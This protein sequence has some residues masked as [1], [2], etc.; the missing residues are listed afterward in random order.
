ME[1]FIFMKKKDKRARLFRQQR[2]YIGGKLKIM[3][4]GVDNDAE[5]AK[6]E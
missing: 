3:Y 5:R 2:L 6:Y 4:D 1:K